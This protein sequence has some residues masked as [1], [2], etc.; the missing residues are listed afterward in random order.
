MHTFITFW[1]SP[2]WLTVTKAIV[3][4]AV[5]T[6]L[7]LTCL[8]AVH[9]KETIGT[10]NTALLTRPS[11]QTLAFSCNLKWQKKIT[12]NAQKFLPQSPNCTV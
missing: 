3:S 5:T 7:A 9:T 11:W 4:A 12:T 10:W 6:I 2:S 1:T 8:T